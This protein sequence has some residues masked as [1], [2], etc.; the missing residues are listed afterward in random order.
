[1]TELPPDVRD[2]AA[3]AAA[4]AFRTKFGTTA[5]TTHTVR[6]GAVV[7]AVAEVL[8][9]GPPVLRAGDTVQ[10]YDAGNFRSA[11]V[12]FFGNLAGPLVVE[13][14]DE[15]HDALKARVDLLTTALTGL[16]A[17]VN[18]CAHDCYCVS[19][20]M[21]ESAESLLSATPTESEA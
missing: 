4:L 13:P 8:A 15:G 16:V 11:V 10:I 6:W 20:E 12:K 3:Q 5:S 1:M 2:R 17:A 9:T 19:D 14:T 21:L 18:D 7:D